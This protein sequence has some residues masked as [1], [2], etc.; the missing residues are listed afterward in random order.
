PAQ[1]LAVELDLDL[2]RLPLQDVVA[3]G[4]VDAHRPGA[5]LALRDVALEAQVLERVVLGADREAVVARG[6]GEE[7]RQRPRREGA[8]ALEAEVAVKARRA[9]LLDHEARRGRLAALGG[10]T[11]LRDLLGLGGRSGLGGL[12]GLRTFGRVCAVAARPGL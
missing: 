10:R 4:V 6:V 8:V 3:A 5:V 2:A 11:G 12:A 9:V 7:T 1:P